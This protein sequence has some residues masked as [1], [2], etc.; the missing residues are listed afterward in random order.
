[1]LRWA[2][3]RPG[4]TAENLSCSVIKCVALTFDDGPALYRPAA[5]HPDRQRR[6]SHLLPDRQQP[7]TPPAPGV[8]RTGMEIGIIPGN[9]PNMTTI[10]AR[11]YP[12]PILQG[13]RCDRRG[14]RPHADVGSP[15]RR[16]VQRRG[17]RQGRGRWASRNLWGRYTFDWI[18]DSNTAAH[19]VDDADQAGFGGAVPR[20]LPSTVDAWCTSSSRCSKPTAIACDRQR[21]SFSGR[22]RQKQ[23]RQPGKRSTCQRI[24][25]FRSARSR[26]RCPTLHRPAPVPNFLITIL[27][28]Q[29]LPGGP[30]NG[31]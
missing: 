26:R 11:G 13:Q 10:P 31:A 16:T 15:G 25:T 21:A 9:T 8:S 2:V 12:R 6:Q 23:L 1:M 7:P 27:R 17:A 18:N 14:D 19:R 3:Q 22:G 5:A 24:R 4:H 28:G 29:N 30:N 20:H